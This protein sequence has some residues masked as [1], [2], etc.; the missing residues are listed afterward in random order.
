MEGRGRGPT[1]P[2]DAREAANDDQEHQPRREQNTV[3]WPTPETSNHS[4]YYLTI[5]TGWHIA[6]T[7]TM[8][9]T[10]HLP[11]T[12]AS[13][14]HIG[15]HPQTRAREMANLRTSC[16]R[17]LYLTTMN[18]V[19]ERRANQH[20]TET[21]PTPTGYTQMDDH[22]VRPFNHPYVPLPGEE[23][24]L[25]ALGTLNPPETCTLTLY[26]DKCGLVSPLTASMH[27]LALP[28]MGPAHLSC[29]GLTLLAQAI[30]AEARSRED[31]TPWHRP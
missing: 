8:Q 15:N 20:L 27:R 19:T 21:L 25:V 4:R 6:A 11:P 28:H 14:R 29:R 17:G 5:P 18:E 31:F 22:Q 3:P 7:T 2:P 10:C 9:T 1:H 24:A 30:I 26:I 13:T 16:L 12:G 23:D